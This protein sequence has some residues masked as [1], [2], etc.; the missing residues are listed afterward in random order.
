MWT[1]V[2]LRCVATRTHSSSPGRRSG[3]ARRASSDGVAS[4]CKPRQSL[5]QDGPQ[6]WRILKLFALSGS[7]LFDALL[8]PFDVLI[9]RCASFSKFVISTSRRISATVSA[10]RP[11]SSHVML[12]FH[13]QCILVV[14]SPCGHWL[15]SN[16]LS[17]LYLCLCP[18]HSSRSTITVLGFGLNVF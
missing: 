13:P 5:S 14:A 17:A 3:Y 6:C 16:L 9:P 10:S 12:S 7:R 15:R 8:T 2:S 18:C 11:S 1:Q 4:S